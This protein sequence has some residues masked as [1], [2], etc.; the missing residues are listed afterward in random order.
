MKQFEFVEFFYDAVKTLTVEQQGQF[1][2][3]MCEYYFDGKRDFPNVSNVVIGAANVCI[4]YNRKQQQ[5]K[6]NDFEQV[7]QWSKDVLDWCKTKF[8]S[9]MWLIKNCEQVQLDEA[10][11]DCSK[12]LSY[13]PIEQIKKS[14]DWIR[15][16]YDEKYY[17]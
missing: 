14:F 9:C 10:I 11:E 16:K 5:E 15:N 12:D 1:L 3:V 8:D 7:K 6:Q 13:I 4:N 2:K 17:L